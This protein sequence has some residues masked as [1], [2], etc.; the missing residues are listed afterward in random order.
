VPAGA[1]IHGSPQLARQ[2]ETTQPAATAAARSRKAKAG[3]PLFIWTSSPD[4]LA[5]IAR[6]DGL[7]PRLKRFPCAHKQTA[8]PLNK[9]HLLDLLAHL[10]SHQVL[11]GFSFVRGALAATTGTSGQNISIRLH[12]ECPYVTYFSQTQF[13]CSFSRQYFSCRNAAP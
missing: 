6:R 1:L 12:P 13:V 10:L 3:T 8:L 7:L 9:F 5:T 2:I 11:A 4:L